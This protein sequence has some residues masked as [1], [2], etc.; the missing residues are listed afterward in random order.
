MN[1]NDKNRNK[2][3]NVSSARGAGNRVGV[4]LI[5][6]LGGSPI[7]LRFVSQALTQAGYTVACPVLKGLAGGTDVSAMSTWQDWY[8]AVQQ[9]HDELLETCDIVMVGGLSA[10]AVLA[11]RLAALRPDDVHGLVLFSPTLWP[12]G[13]SI[14]WYFNLFRLVKTKWTARLFHFK[15][16]APHGIKDDRIRAFVTDAM[17]SQ[18]G[19]I[20]D[21]FGRGGGLVFEFIRLVRKVRPLLGQIRHH[22]L[23]F[24]PRFDDQSDMSNAMTLQRK[25]SGRVDVSI[26]DDCYHMVTLDRQRAVVVE[27]TVA[28]IDRQVKRHIEATERFD[29]AAKGAM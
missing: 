8:A 11:L 17:S 24:H 25:L 5:H 16:R 28:F 18:E 19:S 26:L 7:E 10:G 14:P 20:E 4:L 15:A 3:S 22:T 29:G 6:S 23:I 21:I 1:S 13:W 9:A 27:G 12:N 2:Q